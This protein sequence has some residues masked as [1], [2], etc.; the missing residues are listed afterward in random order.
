MFENIY[1]NQQRPATTGKFFMKSLA[2]FTTE[3]F[4]MTLKISWKK[5]SLM[6]TPG[7]GSSETSRNLQTP[8][9]NIAFFL[10]HNPYGIIVIQLR[11]KREQ[12]IWGYCILYVLEKSNY[13]TD[14]CSENWYQICRKLSLQFWYHN[15]R[16]KKNTS[17]RKSLNSL[18]VKTISR[19]TSP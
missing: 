12:K 7:H 14:L 2:C 19:S 1:W 8:Q 3:N 18:L 6:M 13:S 16:K 11:I 4:L 17:S 5:R 10:W 15:N 9:A